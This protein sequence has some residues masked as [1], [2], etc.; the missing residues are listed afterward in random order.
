MFGVL[1]DCSARISILAG[2]GKALKED[3]SLLVDRRREFVSMGGFSFA[4]L[5]ISI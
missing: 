5:S 2:N 4:H 3:P 1:S